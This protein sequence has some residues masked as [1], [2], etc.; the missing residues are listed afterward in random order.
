VAPAIN[1]ASDGV[2]RWGK[3]ARA[4]W[5]GGGPI[6][7]A[8]G[9]RRLTLGGSPRWRTLKEGNSR[10]PAEGAVKEKA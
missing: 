1:P 4:S 2:G 10:W 6:L 9:R 5:I 3:G 7:G 8:E